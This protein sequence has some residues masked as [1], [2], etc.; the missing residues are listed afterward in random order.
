MTYVWSLQ[1]DCLISI[2]ASTIMSCLRDMCFRPEAREAQFEF[3]GNLTNSFL[4]PLAIQTSERL[5]NLKLHNS[6][7]FRCRAPNCIPCRINFPRFGQKHLGSKYCISWYK[8]NCLDEGRWSIAENVMHIVCLCLRHQDVA[9]WALGPAEG[10]VHYNNTH[11]TR[12]YMLSFFLVGIDKLH[13]FWIGSIC[14]YRL[15]S[16]K[17]RRIL[18]SGVQFVSSPTICGG[19]CTCPRCATEQPSIIFYVGQDYPLSD[20]SS[21]KLVFGRQE[22]ANPLTVLGVSEACLAWPWSSRDSESTCEVGYKR[23][24]LALVLLTVLETPTWCV[25]HLTAWC[26]LCR[27]VPTLRS[28]SFVSCALAAWLWL[29]VWMLWFL[30]GFHCN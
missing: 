28:L 2:K 15:C 25:L 19:V 7:A 24:L 9:N 26:R 16:V 21:R 18:L 22:A 17:H 3:A 6:L 14:L 30:C 12:P 8:C 11:S 1:F 4:W 27:T 5:L 13:W 20:R 29:A 10:Y 23:A